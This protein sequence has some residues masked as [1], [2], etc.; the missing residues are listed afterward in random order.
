M[1]RLTEHWRRQG[2][3]YCLGAAAATFAGGVLF[4]RGGYL[5]ISLV[6][7]FAGAINLRREQLPELTDEEADR[8]LDELRQLGYR[9][10]DFQH[11]DER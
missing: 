11:D 5:L 7:A 4:G 2:S 1:S 9:P 6:W 10:D 3:R 8:L